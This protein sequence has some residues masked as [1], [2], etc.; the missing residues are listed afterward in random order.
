[1]MDVEPDSGQPGSVWVTA[2]NGKDP[3]RPLW[4]WRQAH[5]T[6]IPRSG[7]P[8]MTLLRSDPAADEALAVG[9]HDGQLYL[10]DPAS[11]NLRRS[12]ALSDLPVESAPALHP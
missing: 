9:S 12:I 10:L 7:A 8:A 4:E 5:H 6:A 3:G 1:G 11:G 2:I